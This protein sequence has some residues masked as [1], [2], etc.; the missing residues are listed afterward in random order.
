MES[1]SFAHGYHEIDESIVYDVVKHDI[2]ELK[3]AIK[4]L[5]RIIE[6]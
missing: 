5:I 3:N 1:Q 4:E 6:Q 2:P